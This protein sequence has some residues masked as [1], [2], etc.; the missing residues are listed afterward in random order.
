MSV[1]WSRN[2]IDPEDEDSIIF[3]GVRGNLEIITLGASL[4]YEG[5]PP[6]PDEI[7]TGVGISNP[8]TF[9]F[10]YTTS[11]SE[12]KKSASVTINATAIETG[13]VFNQGYIEYSTPDDLITINRMPAVVLDVPK[14]II[15]LGYYS[16]LRRTVLFS[17]S[18]YVDV[19]DIDTTITTRSAKSYK[20][21]ITNNWTIDGDALSYL[22]KN[23]DASQA[24]ELIT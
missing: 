11:I 12:S 5:D 1:E 19:Y 23:N 10:T 18:V 3:E 6:Y 20:F 15:M 21:E 9:P 16:D 24:P 14:N 22:M 13:R 4:V 7:I 17:F 2:P 8:E